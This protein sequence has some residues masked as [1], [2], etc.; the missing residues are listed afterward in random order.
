M[1]LPLFDRL[2]PVTATNGKTRGELRPLLGVP[3]LRLVVLDSCP[4]R[5]D[6]DDT[7]TAVLQRRGWGCRDK[8]G[9][10]GTT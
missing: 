5:L 2:F 6:E 1:L 7:G 10:N 3:L 9:S 4:K 8:D